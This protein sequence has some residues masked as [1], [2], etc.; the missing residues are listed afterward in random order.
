VIASGLVDGQ[1]VLHRYEAAPSQPDDGEDSVPCSTSYSA[2]EVLTR[3]SKKGASC[4][5]VSFAADGQTLLAGFET[6]TILQLDAHTGKVLTRMTKAHKAGIN[7]MLS[8]SGQQ[9]LLAAGD[10]SGGLQV[11]DLRSQSA[12]YQY[13]KHTDFISGL[14]QHG[15]SGSKQQQEMLVAVS[16]DGTLSVHDLRAG[17][18]LARS[19]TDADDELLSGEAMPHSSSTLSS[20]LPAEAPICGLCYHP[21]WQSVVTV[22]PLLAST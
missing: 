19:E 6:G 15:G 22:S 17:K 5:A 21:A 20:L 12:V 4:R 16:G 9:A 8:L 3:S 11:W 14:T 18:L 10:D 1:I 7:R 13:S 2:S